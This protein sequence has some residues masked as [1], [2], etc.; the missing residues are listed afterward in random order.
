MP[1]F[2]WLLGML[3][4]ACYESSECPKVYVNGNSGYHFNH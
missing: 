2:F 4:S 3:A 1:S